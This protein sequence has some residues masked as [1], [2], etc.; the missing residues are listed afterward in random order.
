M[1]ALK[2][3]ADLASATDAKGWLSAWNKRVA[4]SFLHLKVP[5]RHKLLQAGLSREVTAAAAAGLHIL[6]HMLRD[7]KQEALVSDMLD[8]VHQVLQTLVVY[9]TGWTL[10]NGVCQDALSAGALAQLMQ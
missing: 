8:T 1:D 9:S 3:F 6:M 2:Y 4:T 10:P 5:A 7:S